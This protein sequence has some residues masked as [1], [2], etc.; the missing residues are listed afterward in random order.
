MGE[1]SQCDPSATLGRR[2]SR[3]RLGLQKIL[4]AEL[5]NDNVQWF[6]TR[7]DA[8]KKQPDEEILENLC[9]HQLQQSEQLKPLLLLYIQDTVC[10]K[11]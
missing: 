8:I 10:S 2:S 4:K 7:W 3:T 9:Y 6:N 11:R 5:K 1:L